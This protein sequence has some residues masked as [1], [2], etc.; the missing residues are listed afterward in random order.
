[1]RRLSWFVMPLALAA[2]LLT[3]PVLADPVP[4]PPEPTLES[5]LPL[6]P[7]KP[8]SLEPAHS[9]TGAAGKLALFAIVVAGG[10]WIW[11]QR[12]K[13]G[14]KAEE[15]ELRVIR[16]TTIGVRSEL[17]LLE[18]EGQKLLIG[19]T[20]SSMQTLY[21]L[22]DTSQDEAAASEVAPERRIANLLESRI[23]PRE[24]LRETVRELARESGKT[25]LVSAKS[26]SQD[27]DDPIFEGQAA[28][29][30]ALGARK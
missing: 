10:L 12:A 2:T 22:P 26:S 6:R 23:A 4:A 24:E 15:A 7:N 13:K 19:V 16:R 30:R 1:M 11:K 20:P 17:I 21:L 27:D 29:L 5:T 8:L 28:G 25:K 3:G 9:S 18:L 14:P